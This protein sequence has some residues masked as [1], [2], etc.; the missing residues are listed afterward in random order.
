VGERHQVDRRVDPGARVACEQA[1]VKENVPDV[2]GDLLDGEQWLAARAQTVRERAG[3]VVTD[4]CS[5]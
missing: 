2:S 4:S 3:T 1:V 5:R